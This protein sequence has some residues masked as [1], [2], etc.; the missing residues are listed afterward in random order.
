ML[1]RDLN[2]FEAKQREA[3]DIARAILDGKRGVC[4]GCR[5]LTRLAHDIVPDWRVDP[6]F[7]VFGALDSDSD[8]FPLGDARRHWHPSVLSEL[9]SEREQ[10]E[11]RVRPKVTVACLSIVSRFGAA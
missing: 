11:E 10:L 3:A 7:V 1:S 2:T 9:D 4:D 6:D 8:R 5:A